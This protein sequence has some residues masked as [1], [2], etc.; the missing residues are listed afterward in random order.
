[1]SWMGKKEPVK[2]FK[3]I[4]GFADDPSSEQARFWSTFELTN[5]FTENVLEIIIIAALY[6]ADFLS[7][8][9]ILFSIPMLIN[10]SARI[11]FFVMRVLMKSCTECFVPIVTAC[12]AAC[13][14]FTTQCCGYYCQL[15]DDVEP[16]TMQQNEPQK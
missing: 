1:M 4:M 13:C 8:A 12:C 2:F 3:L 9:A 5:V 7:P 11:F 15:C 14:G 16:Q 6:H 10:T